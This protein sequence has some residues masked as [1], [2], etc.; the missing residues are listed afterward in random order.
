MFFLFLIML[1]YM[2]F[3]VQTKKKVPSEDSTFSSIFGKFLIKPIVVVNRIH[4]QAL[5]MAIFL[6]FSVY[7]E[8]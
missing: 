8:V 2:I 3:E 4:K 6:V 1:L 5:K 7:S